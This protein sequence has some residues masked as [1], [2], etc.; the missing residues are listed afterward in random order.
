MHPSALRL[1]VIGMVLTAVA[2]AQDSLPNCNA[3]ECA[4]DGQCDICL[5]PYD[6]TEGKCPTVIEALQLPVCSADVEVG[7]LC[8]TFFTAAWS[9]GALPTL[10]NCAGF[11]LQN[12]A[13]GINNLVA[14]TNISTA[15]SIGDSSIY[16]RSACRFHSP[17]SPPPSPPSPPLPPIP[18]FLPPRPPQV[19]I[20]H[21]IIGGIAAVLLVTAVV[22]KD[23]SPPPS[24]SPPPPSPS[25]KSPPMEA[26]ASS[27][28]INFLR[29]VVK[30]AITVGVSR[31]SGFSGQNMDIDDDFDFFDLFG[32][33]DGDD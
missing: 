9:C 3:N 22:G 21:K 26:T 1:L 30:V 25:P 27:G 15:I 33:D 14:G 17:P 2:N 16:V 4:N 24:P 29:M 8:K 7:G 32:G 19:P 23:R 13:N 11:S 5:M 31:F 6:P 18:P 12:L 20:A 28:F 10:R